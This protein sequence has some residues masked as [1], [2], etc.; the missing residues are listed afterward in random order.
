MELLFTNLQEERHSEV[1]SKCH[2]PGEFISYKRK[3]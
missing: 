3:L 2:T 1:T